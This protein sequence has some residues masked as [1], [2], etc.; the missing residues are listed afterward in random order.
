MMEK[1]FDKTE[2]IYDDV[3]NW[4]ENGDEEVKA[5]FRG[6]CM[7]STVS[8]TLLTVF[9]WL[10]HPEWILN[11]RCNEMIYRNIKAKKGG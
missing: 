5:A 8:M 11:K 7:F 2:K 9:Y 10:G 4:W 1:I 6:W 3:I